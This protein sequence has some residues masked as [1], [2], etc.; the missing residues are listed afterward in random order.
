[1]PGA[2]PLPVARVARMIDAGPDLVPLARSILE[3]SSELNGAWAEGRGAV[4]RATDHAEALARLRVE[5]LGVVALV[6]HGARVGR[7]T[8]DRRYDLIDTNEVS[9]Q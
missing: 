8:R 4:R 3:A 1:M 9:I 5:R 7:L 6:V 2:D